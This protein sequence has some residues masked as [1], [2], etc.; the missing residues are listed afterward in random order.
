M[1]SNP[2]HKLVLP[3]WTTILPRKTRI[4]CKEISSFFGYK[5]AGQVNTLVYRGHFPK[6]EPELTQNKSLM[7]LNHGARITKGYWLLGTLRDY[8]IEQNQESKS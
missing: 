4:T 8:E 5:S 1:M 6:C 7:R 2:M 3:A